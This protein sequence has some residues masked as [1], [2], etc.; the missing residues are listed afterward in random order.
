MAGGLRRT[1]TNSRDPMNIFNL[2]NSN[3]LLAMALF[4]LWPLLSVAMDS[5][6]YLNDAQS[7]YDK[8]DYDAAVIQ[9]KNALLVEPDNGQAR[10][11]L[12]LAYLELQKG[13]SAYK[14]L[15]RA[16][17]LGI[18]RKTVLPPLGRALLMTGQGDELLK[19][20]FVESDDPQEL[21]ASILLL[22][23]QAYL[24]TRR[25]ELAGDKF[26]RV[27]ELDPEMAGAI[28]GKAHLAYHDMD[29]A[30]ASRLVSQVITLDPGNADAWIL[31]GELLRA[32]NRQA[33]A[34]SA[35]QRALDA[36]PASLTARMG[37]AAAH[38]ALGEHEKAM[39]EIKQIQEASPNLYLTHYLMS[40]AMYQNQELDAAEESIRL[41]L[42]QEPDHAPSQLLAGTIAY[43]QGQ[44]NQAERYL[45]TYWGRHPDN[46]Q[47]TKLLAATLM[48]IN[49]PAKT[50]E[51]LES[52]KSAAADDA[53]YLS[54]LGSAYLATGESERG[55]DYLERAIA[56]EPDV[57]GL[58]AQLAIGQLVHGEVDQAVSELQSAVELD[59]NLLQADIML[60]LVYL[61]KK[62]YQN[63]LTT[64]DALVAKMPENPVIHN[65]KGA[66]LLGNDDRQGAAK[67]FEDALGLQ[68]DFI[69]A[70]LNLAQ[71]DLMNGD[72]AAAR[73]R[74]Q[75][76]LSHDAG[77]LKALLALAVMAEGEGRVD[78][79]EKWLMTAHEHHPDE[80]KP[81][82]MLVKYYQREGKTLKAMDLARKL[83][84][85]HPRDI[86]VLETLAYTQLE[87]GEDE[88][89]LASMRTL[90]ELSP[91][92]PEPYY[93][94]ALVQMKMRLPGKAR[95]NL[96]RA[97]ELKAD[98][99]AAQVAL[100]R[101]EIDEKHFEAALEIANALKETHPDA[102]SGYALE[103]DIHYTR[104]EFESAS[105]AYATAFGKAG[106][107]QLARKLFQSRM[108]A[109][110]QDAAYEGLGQWL[111]D[112]PEDTRLRAMLAMAL[113]SSGQQQSAIAEYLKILDSDPDNVTVLNN[114]AWLYQESSDPQGVK[115]A[116]RAHELAPGRPE[117]TDTLGWLLVQNGDT[118]RGLVLLQEAR[119][120]APHIPDIHYHMAAA[121]YKAG[122]IEE[123]RKE[124]DRLLKT[125]K[126]FPELDEARALHNKLAIQ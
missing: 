33:E 23:G 3:R 34:A 15:G 112:H 40:L 47:A 43:Q 64:A 110:K 1:G 27:L 118:N 24:A 81:G 50:V 31:K 95:A 61:E 122:R 96:Q 80:I 78:E 71:I 76:I 86:S 106:S 29:K 18:S 48:K 99:P 77:N 67:A 9:L 10:L 37:K 62:D 58:R 103:G 8:G 97:L 44:M 100:G 85:S 35:F 116:E 45:R 65:L 4:S 36:S 74:Y 13:Q 120:K 73:A 69:P 68:P 16:R 42:K 117:V 87:A 125:G 12:G 93:R 54:L 28:L 60:V 53:Q 49:E 104:K 84:V 2:R 17:D 89:A 30:E 111:A 105:D 90:V 82:L 83:A 20:F 108:Q 46:I 79:V 123:S 38:I 19:T 94:L 7:Y 75:R 5:D 32:A 126:T 26:S 39:A 63:A 91:E 14:E 6:E 59:P 55:L 114:L 21:R 51:V 98:Y 124:L 88:A 57:A 25:Y 101:L 115:Y 56:L 70:H 92:S 102:G 66:A 113:Q 72:S 52:G 119:V 107:A 11:L 121:L 41:A 109:G 22:Q